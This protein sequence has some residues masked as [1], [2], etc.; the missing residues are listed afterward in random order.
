MLPPERSMKIPRLVKVVKSG[1]RS[2]CA[3]PSPG[4]GQPCP[5][6]TDWRW[7]VLSRRHQLAVGSLV[8]WVQVRCL[9]GCSMSTRGLPLVS[10]VMG[11][12]SVWILW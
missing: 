4:R 8:L 10:M 5:A 11:M 1:A 6:V 7:A 3:N 9:S 12:L 2:G